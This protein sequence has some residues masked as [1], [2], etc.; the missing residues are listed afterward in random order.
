MP[1]AFTPSKS[2][3]EAFHFVRRVASDLCW[4]NLVFPI[5]VSLL[6]FSAGIMGHLFGHPVS[7]YFYFGNLLAL[8]FLLTVAAGAT[9][10]P[11]LPRAQS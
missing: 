7:R 5:I 6:P 8:A 1:T 4:A 10:E 2:R 11:D 3:I 9:A